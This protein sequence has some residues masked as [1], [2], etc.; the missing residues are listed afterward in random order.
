MPRAQGLF[1]QAGYTVMPYP[2]DF[3]ANLSQPWSILDF[4]PNAD[5]FQQTERA[6]RELIGRAYYG[7]L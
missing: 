5:A 4:L 7:R 1:E 6:W 2:V 3:Y